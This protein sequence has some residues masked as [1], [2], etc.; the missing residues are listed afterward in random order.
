MHLE[1]GTIPAGYAKYIRTKILLLLLG[2]VLLFVLAVLSIATG[3][4][5]YDP[6]EV[7]RTLFMDHVSR[8]LDVVV[9]N[10]RLP[11][12]LAAILA[13][14]G[15]SVAGVIMQSVLGNPWVRPSR[16]GYPRPRLSG[17]LFR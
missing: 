5:S 6:L 8:Q 9:F 2:L 12:V 4:V 14:A 1:E 7:L 15:L 17:R 10:I 16:W 11:Q 13:G 3:P